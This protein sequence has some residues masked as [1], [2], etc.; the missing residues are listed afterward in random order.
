MSFILDLRRFVVVALAALFMAA[1]AGTATKES[2]GEYIDDT[3][4]TAKVKAVLLGDS[5][6]SGWRINVETFKGAV[7]LSGFANSLAE[8]RKAVTLARGVKGVKSVQDDI[9]VP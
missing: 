7:Q 8:R 3:A 1:C 2:T 5:E 4:I 6:I 9:I